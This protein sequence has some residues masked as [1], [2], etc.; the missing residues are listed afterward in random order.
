MAPTPQ[1]SL[2]WFISLFKR[3][4][5]EAEKSEDIGERGK[6]LNS[7][8]TY[9]V[10]VN[11]CRS[12][13][14]KHKLT[15]SFMMLVKI[16]QNAGRIDP[17]EWRYLLA[18]PTTT[19]FDTPKPAKAEWLTDQMW[20]ELWNVSQLTNFKGFQDEVANHLDHYR[21]M[22]DSN[23]AHKHPLTDIWQDSLDLFQRLLILRCLRPDKCINGVQDFISAELGPEFIEPPPF[24]LSACY[25][26][27]SPTTPLIFVLSPGA[28][29]MQDLLKLAEELKMSKRFEQVSLGKGQGPKAEVRGIESQACWPSL[30]PYGDP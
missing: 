28:D 16:L 6:T 19:S 1:Y 2:A 12:L 9:S 21:E 14:E 7:Y 20:A 25:R 5:H 22:F 3:A 26:E 10:Y 17:A 24:D 15:F 18:G 23:E 13:F 8:F 4:I 27:A 30:T 11:V 29:P